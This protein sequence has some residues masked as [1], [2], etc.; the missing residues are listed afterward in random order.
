MGLPYINN[1]ILFNSVQ[2]KSVFSHL[3]T[4]A[5]WHCLHSHAAAAAMTDT[6]PVRRAHSSKPAA[7]GLLL[8]A[9][10]GTD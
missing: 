7:T 8:W 1:A 6:S 9:D 4:L 2:N 10:A 5:T 3:R